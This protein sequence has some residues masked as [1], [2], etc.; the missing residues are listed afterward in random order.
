[1]PAQP[2]PPSGRTPAGERLVRVGG[3]LFLLGVLASAVTVTPLLTGDDPF[4]TA[5]YVAAMLAPVGFGVALAGIVRDIRAR[6][7]HRHIRA[8]TSHE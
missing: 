5:A 2:H 7:R 3:V 8:S 4:P 6:R 1:M